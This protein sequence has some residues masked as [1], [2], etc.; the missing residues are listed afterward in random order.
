MKTLA[1]KSAL[2]EHLECLTRRRSNTVMDQT[3]QRVSTARYVRT[4][5]SDC[6]FTPLML[7]VFPMKFS[8]LLSRRVS[9]FIRSEWEDSKESG[10]EAPEEQSGFTLGNTFYGSIFVFSQFIKKRI[11]WFT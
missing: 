5:S 3:F 9:I 11:K 10:Y 1:F 8:F 7:L 6:C 4:C 2:V